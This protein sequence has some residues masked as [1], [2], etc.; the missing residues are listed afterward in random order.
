MSSLLALVSRLPWKRGM[1]MTE[2]RAERLRAEMQVIGAALADPSYR[3]LILASGIEVSDFR[4]NIHRAAFC[5]LRDYR[6]SGPRT[7]IQMLTD[8][9]PQV[10][11]EDYI[12]DLVNNADVYDEAATIK[13]IG[14]LKSEPI[15]V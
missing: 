10:Y 8:A 2:R 12:A 15:G 9:A 14:V 5:S 1:A 3:K 11:P 4:E 13:A 7:V 6:Y